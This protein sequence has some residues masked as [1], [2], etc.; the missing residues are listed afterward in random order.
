MGSK[1]GMAQIL[2]VSL[3]PFQNSW[4]HP[5]SLHP[6]ATVILDTILIGG[7]VYDQGAL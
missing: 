5:A 3:P 2:C 4:L 7:S 1:V 6:S